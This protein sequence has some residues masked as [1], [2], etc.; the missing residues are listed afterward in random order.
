MIVSNFHERF[1]LNKFLYN[2]A[3][4]TSFLGPDVSGNLDLQHSG[5]QI[6]FDPSCFN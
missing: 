2:V 3:K 5:L 4:V 1:S 6:S